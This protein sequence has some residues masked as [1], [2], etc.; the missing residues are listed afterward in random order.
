MGLRW[1]QGDRT[2]GISNSTAVQG[3]L[4]ELT[5]EESVVVLYQGN[6]LCESFFW[7]KIYARGLG[8]IEEKASIRLATIWLYNRYQ[9]R[10][11]SRYMTLDPNSAIAL[12]GTETVNLKPK[13]E[14]WGWTQWRGSPHQKSRGASS[15]PL[16]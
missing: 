1:F 7:R 16:S 8:L 2:P 15:P 9:V 10:C 6:P 13:P 3:V 5:H 14:W 12:R 4:F 11:K